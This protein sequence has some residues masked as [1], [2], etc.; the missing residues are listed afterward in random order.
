MTD[1]DV[2]Y[3]TPD[4]VT[5]TAAELM[6]RM[7]IDAYVAFFSLI[8]LATD[9]RSAKARVRELRDAANAAASERAQ[10]AAER[11]A[12]ARERAE[13]D[14]YKAKESAKVREAQVELANA[15]DWREDALVEREHRVD[16]FERAWA[17]LPLPG[18][19]RENFPLYGGLSRSPPNVSGLQKARFHS[20]HGRLPHVDERLDMP[21]G[22][23]DTQPE[24]SNTTL[25]TDPQGLEFPGHTTITRNAPELEPPVGA[26]IGRGRRRNAPPMEPAA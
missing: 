5:D 9:P 8:K 10:A 20:R 17:G 19:D 23:S 16:Q 21:V 13:F 26:R 24:Q 3:D 4:D 22:E 12:L 14:E 7:P 18:E 11:E 15:K 25:R 1:L 2:T 6:Q